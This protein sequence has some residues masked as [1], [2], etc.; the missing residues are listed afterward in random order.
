MGFGGGA[1]AGPATTLTRL[2]RDGS[3]PE[4]R[5]QRVRKEWRTRHGN[6]R[7]SIRGKGRRMAA[8]SC[9]HTEDQTVPVTNANTP[10]MS[11]PT[12][13]AIE[14]AI[15]KAWDGSPVEGTN[16]RDASRDDS[17]DELIGQEGSYERGFLLGVSLLAVT[18][19][20]A[21]LAVGWTAMLAVALPLLILLALLS[22]QS[23]RF[24]VDGRVDRVRAAQFMISGFLC[25]PMHLVN[26]QDVLTRAEKALL[27]T[28][29]SA[30]VIS[31]IVCIAGF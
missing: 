2:K 16:E 11:P 8:L 4:I 30:V 27:C 26:H 14:V 23:R 17:L 18:A 10:L 24:R 3:G 22:H 9:P 12:A 13:A 28:S 1:D 25:A 20:T 31:T 21:R 15:A 6:G 5:C 19:L 29:W 7:H